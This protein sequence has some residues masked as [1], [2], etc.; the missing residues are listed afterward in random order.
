MKKPRTRLVSMSISL[1][2]TALLGLWLQPGVSGA[3]GPIGSVHAG[4]NK[5][6]GAK[7]CENCHNADASGNQWAAWAHA[8][9][10]TAYETLLGEDAKRLAAEAGVSDPSK[11]ETC[12]R[13]HVTAYGKPKEL[14]KKSFDPKAGVGCESCHGPGNDHARARFRAANAASDDEGFGDEEEEAT[15]TE[16]PDGEIVASVERETCLG[17]HNHDSPSYKPFCFYKF[18]SEIL[19]LNP[20]KPR[21]AEE[22][23]KILVCGCG[24][25]CTCDGE[26]VDGCGVAPK[27]Q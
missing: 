13:C 22:R 21:T 1:G 11:S 27:E 25:A 2:L 19:H 14:F 10:S 5:Y 6:I 12:L 23:A 7:K 3:S 4:P 8:K 18:R 9:H 15:Y 16:I 17:C 26:C 24:D 20:L